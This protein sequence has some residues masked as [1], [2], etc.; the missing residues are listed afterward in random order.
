MQPVEPTLQEEK[1]V[2]IFKLRDHRLCADAALGCSLWG[3]EWKEPIKPGNLTQE[4]KDTKFS[5]L[6]WWNESLLHRLLGRHVKLSSRANSIFR[7]VLSFLGIAKL[8]WIPQCQSAS[9]L[10]FF[11]FCGT[12]V[13]IQGLTLAR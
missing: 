5:P 4:P 2:Y 7:A 8:K 9:H 10:F 12:G 11:F 3:R 13:W 1:V 6:P